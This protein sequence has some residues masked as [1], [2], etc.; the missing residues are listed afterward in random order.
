MPPPADKPIVCFVT[1]INQN[2]KSVKAFKA[3]IDDLQETKITWNVF[4]ANGV[5]ANLPQCVVDAW[6][7]VVHTLGNPRPPP[8]APYD[9]PV[10][11]VAGGTLAASALASNSN[12]GSFPIVQAAGGSK[13]SN[14][15][16][17][18]TGFYLNPLP[19]A[20]TICQQQYDL[21]APT[22]LAPAAVL[23]DRTN[24]NHTQ[25]ILHSLTGH[26]TAGTLNVVDINGNMANLTPAALI[27]NPLIPCTSFMLIPNA[28]FYDKSDDIANTVDQA[29]I[30]NAIYP[31]R[32]YKNAH[33]NKNGKQV[34]G[35]KI[36]L[37]FGLAAYYVDSLLN[38]VTLPS[39]TLPWQEAIT[40]P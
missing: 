14:A 40:D 8:A 37:T 33:S 15:P 27:G 16:G 25:D 17:N 7:F 10:V 22:I 5:N 35:H 21:L 30:Q 38:G 34:L 32:E 20:N 13:P 23:Y 11:F 4:P 29:N 12:T 28:L 36:G 6:N 3:L 39:A 26:A 9:V 24:D 31:E 1:P 19:P 18:M 2:A